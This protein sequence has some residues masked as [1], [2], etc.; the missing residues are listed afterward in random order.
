MGASV[1]MTGR[2]DPAW[3]SFDLY[4]HREHSSDALGVLARKQ[5]FDSLARLL[6]VVRDLVDD[7]EL[8][9]GDLQGMLLLD[10]VNEHNATYKRIELVEHLFPL[11]GTLKWPV[12]TMKPPAQ[13]RVIEEINV[14]DV[15]LAAL[16]HH[17]DP[18]AGHSVALWRRIPPDQKTIKACEDI[19][20]KMMV[21]I[22]A[23]DKD[24]AAR[25]VAAKRANAAAAAARQ[26]QQLQAIAPA[27]APSLRGGYYDALCNG[28]SAV[29]DGVARLSADAVTLGGDVVSAGVSGGVIVASALSHKASAA[30][31]A[32]TPSKGEGGDSMPPS[33]ATSSPPVTPPSS[34]PDP[35]VVATSPSSPVPA[36]KTP[37]YKATR[38][39]V[40]LDH[41]RSQSHKL[42]DDV[43]DLP[44]ADTNQPDKFF[45]I[46]GASESRVTLV[47]AYTKAPVSE[48]KNRKA[49]TNLVWA[50]EV[51]A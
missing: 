44:V 39:K 2:L 23:M 1:T 24:H 20:R 29:G 47:D 51:E 8:G 32:L 15:A 43:V 13:S 17:V 25:V 4:K 41:V 38:D 16:E 26:Q 19:D 50:V 5:S 34:A 11:L 9:E 7:P 49:V 31:T 22:A 37:K 35:L 36:A 18:S 48:Y 3:S 21:H 6:R 46:S 30:I 28:A 33:P 10:L 40:Y 45:F 14:Y 12:A 42:L 27:P